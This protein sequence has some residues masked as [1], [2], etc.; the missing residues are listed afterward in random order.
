MTDR[1][2]VV[3]AGAFVPTRTISNERI[4]RA[5][6]GWPAERIEEKVGIRE[7]RFLWD[8]DTETGKAV[9]PPD[10]AGIYPACNVDMCEVAL[11]NALSMALT[12][13]S[14]LDALFVITCSPDQL[15]F[16]H[17]AMALHQRLGCR[18][19]TFAFV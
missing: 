11:N 5:I 6:P 14:E 7:R 13:A 12:S 18:P 2:C 3:G 1:V 9:P 16:N 17:D 10:D 8:F 15:N 19:Y 4:A